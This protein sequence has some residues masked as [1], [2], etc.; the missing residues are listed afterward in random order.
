MAKKKNSWIRYVR[1]AAAGIFLI[2]AGVAFSGLAGRLAPVLHVQFGPALV[3]CFAAF[4]LGALAIVIGIALVTVLFGRFYCSVFCPFGL[5]QD[6]I[7]F[8]SRRKETSVPDLRPVRYG[9]AGVVLGLLLLGW[10]GGFLLFDPYSNF[11]RI[12]AVF[13]LGGLIPLIVIVVLASWKK[14]IYCTTVC[15][16]GTL[17]GLLAKNGLFKLAIKDRCVKC[18][19]CVKFCPTGC[20]DLEKG[21]I[22]NERCI[23]CMNCISR[24]PLG[25]IGFVLP[26]KSETKPDVSRRAFLVN[27]G[28][29]IAGLAA[30]AAL[31]KT[32]L[33]KLAEYAK[34]FKILPPGAGD[35]ARFASKCTACQLCTANCPAKIIV[36][37]PGG[38]GPVS[39]DLSK[40]FC[41][42]DCNRC[43]QV[44]PTGAIRPLT[45][46]VKRKTKIAEAKFDPRKCLV[47]QEGV[48]CGKCAEACPAKAVRLRR[49]GAPFP[50]KTDLCIGCGACQAACPAPE[51]AMTVHEI[52]KQS[53]LEDK[54]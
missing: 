31:A 38:D 43:S 21:Q 26:K 36:P 17:L 25:S 50:V 32:G 35:A 45:L 12:F 46:E 7:I 40:G 15:P 5:L 9:I 54:E 42:Y 29:L 19:T 28:V 13:T 2:L 4:S 52:E 10:S 18:R 16:V 8:L 30:G 48:K 27:S 33:G 39:L 41:R 22:D 11:G 3:S 23:R 14:R 44:C 53:L 47:F 24:C 49:T 37:A 1:L 34:R 6:I 51:K 20:I